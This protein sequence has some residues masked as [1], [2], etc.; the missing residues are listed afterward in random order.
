MVTV[1]TEH[2]PLVLP[3]SE[4]ATRDH[5]NGEP[6]RRAHKEQRHENDEKVAADQI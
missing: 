4:L 6:D 3:V 1:L 2:P 5:V